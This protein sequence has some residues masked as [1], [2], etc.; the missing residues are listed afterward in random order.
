[1]IIKKTTD[2]TDS[3]RIAV[4]NSNNQWLQA[5]SYTAV[6]TI[7]PYAGTVAPDSFMICDGSALDKNEYPELFAVIGYIFGGSDD[8]FNIPDLRGRTLVGLKSDDKDF[9]TIGKSAGEKEHN[10][11]ILEMPAHTHTLWSN[12]AGTDTAAVNTFDNIGYFPSGIITNQGKSVHTG[13]AGSGKPHNNMQPYMVCNYIIKVVNK[14]SNK[15]N[16]IV[17]VKADEEYN[18]DSENAQ[19][20]KAVAEA[21]ENISMPSVDQTYDPTSENAQSGVAVAQAVNGR[22]PKIEPTS[23]PF[24][25]VLTVNGSNFDD[26][27]VLRDE[28][29]FGK[30]IDDPSVEGKSGA[31]SHGG[32]MVQRDGR[33]NLWTGEPVDDQD[34]VPYSMY[35]ALLERVE[36]LETKT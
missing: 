16:I 34:C 1:M 24:L 25:S 29:F 17:N 4:E 12:I 6:G 30:Y 2:M 14:L 15:L 5:L 36:A 21:I 20:G 7:Y 33:G 35:K 3:E 13:S 22:I 10:L 18:P 19:S 8:T 32:Y 9:D 11:T 26:N 27:G 28:A 23:A 31:I